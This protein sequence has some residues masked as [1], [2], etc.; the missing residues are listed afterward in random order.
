MKTDVHGCST[1]QPG[2]EQYEYFEVGGYPGGKKSKR[3]QYDYR[4]PQGKLFSCIAKSLDEARSRRDA[5]L[6]EQEA[7]EVARVLRTGGRR[8][9]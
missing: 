1:T 8:L 4:T 6:K 2:Q 3:V 9:T 5:W 7:R